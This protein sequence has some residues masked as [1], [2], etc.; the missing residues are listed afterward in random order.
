MKKIIFLATLLVAIVQAAA[1]VQIIQQP[2]PQ[3]VAFGQN[4]TFTVQVSSAPGEPVLFQWYFNGKA[5]SGET[6]SSLTIP[7]VQI[8]DLGKYYVRAGNL[9]GTQASSEVNLTATVGAASKIYPAVEVEIP[10]AA[11]R[12]YLLQRSFDLENWFQVGD[13]IQGAGS[14]VAFLFSSRGSAATFYRVLERIEGAAPASI[15][16][17]TITYKATQPNRP[18]FQLAFTGI[19]GGQN[20]NYL[21]TGSIVDNGTFTYQKNQNFGIATVLT[22]APGGIPARYDM[23]FSTRTYTKTFQGSQIES[24]TF[25]Y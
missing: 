5:I 13:P 17:M 18:V 16:G 21:A 20:G 2:Q 23:D 11:G 22:S 1:A 10:T 19:A 14:P 4:A 7:N 9:E 24:G 6:S 8:E 3:E 15:T 12:K 25:T